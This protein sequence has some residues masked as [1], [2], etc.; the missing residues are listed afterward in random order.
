[1]NT[2]TSIYEYA[3]QSLQ[4]FSQ[5]T[6]LRF[7]GKEIT[8]RE[9]F[10]KI[11][12][13]SENLYELG[14]RPGTVVTVHLPNC[15]Q[16]IMAIY[17]VAKIGAVCDLVH[18]L[19]PAQALREGM[20][21]TE[22]EWLITHLPQ[23]ADAAKHTFLVD[24]S[25]HMRFDYKTLYRIKTRRKT[26][27]TAVPFRRLE[28]GTVPM[29]VFPKGSDLAAKAAVYLHSSGSTGRPKTIVLSHSALNNCVANTED[30]FE[31]KDMDKQVSLGVL[32]LFHGFGLEMDMHRNISFGATL[33]LMPRWDAKSAVKLIRKHQV[34]LMVGLPTMYSALLKEPGFQGRRIAQLTRCYVGG[35]NVKPELIEAVDKRLGGGRRML[36]GFGLTE[37]T[38][39]N[40][41]N[42]HQYYKLGTIGYPV[43]NTTAAVMDN[44][45]KLSKTGEGE[46][47]ISSKSLMIG[48]LKDP[49]AT[50]EAMFFADGKQWVRSGDRVMIDADGFIHFRSRIKNIIIRNGYNI[51]PEQVEDVIRSLDGV[52]DVCV[53]GVDDEALRTQNV[54]AVVIPDLEADRDG[55]EQII[56]Q[57]CMENLPRYAVPKQVVFV[58]A[59]PQNAMKKIDRRELSRP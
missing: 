18:A 1:M 9:L 15:P 32:P 28:T 48:Y 54:R 50:E 38:T 26:K 57:K 2:E 4:R 43:R 16:A 45:G 25:D 31:H 13:V 37:A 35:D 49:E 44:S 6:A 52:C 30:F 34:T 24:I 56:R 46:L 7:Y 39:T 11:D 21:F 42:T 41:V 58:S 47:V 53:V 59:F 14:V 33:I 22:S 8:Y 10:E 17:A 19:T 55:L 23:C 3:K 27:E 51:Y 12:L 20:A 40:C 5:K 36:V 29:G